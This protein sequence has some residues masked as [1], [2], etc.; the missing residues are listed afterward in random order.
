VSSTIDA[1]L[2]MAMGED[3]A[4]GNRLNLKGPPSP[5]LPAPRVPPAGRVLAVTDEPLVSV[6]FRW[7]RTCRPAIDPAS[8]TMVMGEDMVKV[9]APGIGNEPGLLATKS[10]SLAHVVAD[11]LEVSSLLPGPCLLLFKAALALHVSSL[12]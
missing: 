11:T 12:Q 2:T 4:K 6:E 5:L 1:S 7:L 9:V 8:L 3:T 10:R